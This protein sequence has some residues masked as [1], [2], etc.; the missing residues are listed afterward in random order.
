M[1]KKG[2]KR[3]TLGQILSKKRVCKKSVIH[4][5]LASLQVQKQFK[6]FNATEVDQ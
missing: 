1:L 6:T 4:F 3:D 2:F 5:P